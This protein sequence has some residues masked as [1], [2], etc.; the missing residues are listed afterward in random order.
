MHYFTMLKVHNIPQLTEWL[1]VSTLFE[2][3]IVFFVSSVLPQQKVAPALGMSA[4]LLLVISL[5][6][7]SL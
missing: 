1:V 6:L 5:E 3:V 4:L 2:T 7:Q